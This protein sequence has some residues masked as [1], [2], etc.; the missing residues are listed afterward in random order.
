MPDYV[1]AADIGGTNI[2]VARV[3][4]TG[5]ITH[6]LR[7][8]TPPAG[9]VAVVSVLA[10]LL[11][12]IPREGVRALGVDVPGLAY[13][14]GVVWAPNIRGWKRMPLGARLQKLLHMPVVVESDRNA[15]VVGEAWKGA[16]RNCRN[17]VFVA[18]GT[19]IG[20]GIL[21]DGH[22][23]RGHGELAGS[24]GWMAVRDRYLAQY[25]ITGCLESHV[26][27]PAIA[28]AARR[29]L[30][31]E[32]S[33]SE[34]ARLAATG[35]PRA[36]SILEQAGFYLGLALANLVSTLNPSMIVVG[37]GVVDAGD[38]VLKT[39]RETMMRWAQPI[40]VRQ[41]R[42]VRSQLGDAASLL[43]VAQLALDATRNFGHTMLD[44]AAVSS[45]QV[46]PRRR[47]KP[48]SERSPA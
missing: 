26:A 48:A 39:A 8:L 21:V 17:V 36:Q 33:G 35:D 10:K 38:L 18:A 42:L 14:N 28:R 41:V 13:S 5:R 30:K 2:R 46:G 7:A 37:G 15:F 3:S 22:L 31:R 23:L 40:A 29:L 34:V 27:G 1:L 44:A 32:I 24:I 20:A 25:K 43:G 11:E 4:S 47:R 19:G 45:Q 9:G 12:Q 6:R 16:A